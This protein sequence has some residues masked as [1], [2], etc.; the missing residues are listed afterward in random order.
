LSGIFDYSMVGV[1]KPRCQASSFT[2]SQFSIQP[3]I[4]ETEFG[5]GGIGVFDTIITF[6]F[7][8]DRLILCLRMRGEIRSG[9]TK[10]L[11]CMLDDGGIIASSR[12]IEHL[13]PLSRI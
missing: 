9:L 3:Q 11:A 8:F 13:F 6:R 4:W 7:I 1:R 5:G 10:A 2:D 12:R